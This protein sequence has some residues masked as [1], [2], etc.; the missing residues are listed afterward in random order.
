MNTPSPL[1]SLRQWMA[2][3]R[4]H[5]FVLTGTDPHDS[6]YLPAC[7]ATR[8]WLTGF[9]GSAGTVVVTPA[10]AW[11][12]T[13]GRYWVQA[14]KQLAG[15]RIGLMR[16]GQAGTPGFLD[17][18]RTNLREG[19]RLA[20]DAATTSW[21]KKLL[22]E[23]A[24]RDRNLTLSAQI[25]PWSQLWPDRPEAPSAL[26]YDYQT[27]FR[28]RTRTSKFSLLRDAME[29]EGCDYLLLSGLDDIAWTLNLRGS[30]IDYNPV[31]LS[32]LILGSK[33]VLLFTD[34]TRVDSSVRRA[35]DTDGVSL[36]PYDAF[37]TALEGLS[38]S[39]VWV[40]GDRTMVR[41]VL[42][43]AG[44][45]LVFRSS[46]T[47]LPKSRRTPAELEALQRALTNDGRAMVRFLVW[48]EET[49]PAGHLTETA[50]AAKLLEFR[51]QG[52]G[53]MGESFA[54]IAGFGAHGAIIHYTAQPDTDARLTGRGLFLLDS[55]GQ[56]YDGTTD[57]TRT[58]ILGNPTGDEIEDYTLVLKA[59]IHLATAVFPKGTRGGILDAQTRSVL[60]RRGRNYN[61]GTG[62]GVGHFLCVHEG[63]QRLGPD[64]N[65]Q[66]LEPGMVCSNE[67]GLYREGRYG[68]RLEN[69]VTVEPDQT[70]DFAEFYRLRTL[71]LCPF[72]RRLIN[73][74]LL[75]GEELQ[76]LNTY[77]DQVYQSLEPG[78]TPRERA[79]LKEKTRPL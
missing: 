72:E 68:I 48:W 26:V 57:I 20:F 40:P 49:V 31:F 32:Y 27:I 42:A 50:C 55:G 30:D 21:Q 52:S 65:P 70:T 75:S 45:R 14:E 6:E 15:S 25:V 28:D 7:W 18:L 54:T 58:L 22:W 77:H 63:P 17:W 24:L 38:G 19:Q 76:W 8:S 11:L 66:P 69:L 1:D 73:H 59:H 56:Y 34:E 62:H 33:E 16:D 2:E 61:H 51:R 60:W 37:H 10:E 12:W 4:L 9:T 64:L 23:D 44:C 5:A 46:P 67:P 39:R 78:L 29:R 74:K 35:L 43:L 41:T 71:T 53:F 79:W 13:D 47:T 3:N 36:Q